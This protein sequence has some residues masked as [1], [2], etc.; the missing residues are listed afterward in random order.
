VCDVTVL[1]DD[2]AWAHIQREAV[3]RGFLETGGGLFGWRDEGDLV[4]ACASGP[5]RKA[6]HRPRSFEAH[7]ATTAAVMTAVER[8]SESRYGY[9]GSWHTHP[10]GEPVPSSTDSETARQMAEQEDLLLPEPLLLILGTSGRIRR[11]RV[12][13]TAA[14]VWSVADGRLQAVHTKHVALATLYCPPIGQLAFPA[15]PV[16]GV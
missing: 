15:S 6:K 11:R 2:D 14:W 7:R 5:G 16:G 4:V 13:G 8:A 12:S 3:R 1:L 10:G 9:L